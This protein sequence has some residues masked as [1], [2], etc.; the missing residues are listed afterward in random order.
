MEILVFGLVVFVL[1][2]YGIWRVRRGGSYDDV[3]RG[4]QGLPD[5]LREKNI[6]GGAVD[7]MYAAVRAP[8]PVSRESGG[9][10]DGGG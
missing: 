6:H 7:G 5:D 8:Q 2:A 1:A 4:R 10:K 9:G 3:D